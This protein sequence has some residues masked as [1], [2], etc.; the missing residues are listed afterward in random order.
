MKF[1]KKSGFFLF[2]LQCLVTIT[3]PAAVAQT[4]PKNKIDFLYYSAPHPIQWDTPTLLIRSTIRNYLSFINP[5]IFKSLF[6][7]DDD[8]LNDHPL[9]LTQ[10]FAATLAQLSAEERDHYVPY[11]HGISHVNVRLQCEGHE[12]MLLGMTG[13]EPQSYYIKKLLF[14]NGA[15][16]TMTENTRGRFYQKEEIEKWIPYMKA[17][18]MMH[19]LSFNISKKN[20]L[21]IKQYLID[22]KNYEQNLVYGG[23]G[24]EPLSGVGAGCSAFAIGVMKVAGLYDDYFEKNFARSIQVPYSMLNYAGHKAELNFYDL[25]F[26]QHSWAQ[27]SQPSLKVSFWDPQL[28]YEWAKKLGMRDISWNKPHQITTEHGSFIIS[29]NAEKIPTPKPFQYYTSHIQSIQ[30][31][32]TRLWKKSQQLNLQSNN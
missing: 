7:Q 2:V 1:L 6:E 20:C 31:E 17:T 4:A 23:L 14:H 15:M 26:K 3:T 5:D 12:E 27:N 24:T 29:V 16:E 8:L 10:Q 30:A 11:P 25:F 21:Q 32:V 18:G 22:Y 9:R 28:M 19:Q 13:I